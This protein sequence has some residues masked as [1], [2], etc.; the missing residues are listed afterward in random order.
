MNYVNSPFYMRDCC[1]AN[2]PY[3]KNCIKFRKYFENQGLKVKSLSRVD[4]GSKDYFKVI[5]DADNSFIKRTDVLRELGVDYGLVHYDMDKSEASYV[6]DESAMLERYGDGVELDF[7]EKGLYDLFKECDEYHTS[8]IKEYVEKKIDWKIK[9]CDI[10]G[11]SF[12][13]KLKDEDMSIDRFKMAIRLDIPKERITATCLCN[14]WVYCINF[15]DWE[16]D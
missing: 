8:P 7:K 4:I 11:D 2:N 1:G 6:I 15:L 16:Q 12:F 3:H 10:T 13:F 9:S 5:F 14:G